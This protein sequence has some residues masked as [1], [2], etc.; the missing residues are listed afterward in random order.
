M[1]SIRRR[2]PRRRN[3]LALTADLSQVL[4]QTLNATA[5]SSPRP[6][7]VGTPQPP[8]ASK[9]QTERRVQSADG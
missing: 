3:R 9:A 7:T 1:A 8:A 6:G 4:S 5:S 2:R